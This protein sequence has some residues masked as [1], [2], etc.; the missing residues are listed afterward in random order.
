MGLNKNVIKGSIILLV[1]FG[2]FN[3]LNFIFQLSMARALSFA[4]YAVLATLFSIIYILAVFSESIQMIL[5]KYS[6]VEKDKGKLNNILRRSLK[7]TS[8]VAGII[9][10]IYLVISFPLAYLLKID[11]L[12]LAINGVIIFMAFISP[13][14]RGVM[15]GKKKFKAL[16]INMVLESGIKLVL[17]VLFVF[18]GWRVYG[19]LIGSIIGAIVALVL[20]FVPLREILRTKEKKSK[21]D[22]IYSFAV[23]AFFVTL[24]IVVF[25]SIDMVIAKIMFS[26]EIAGKY[27]IASILSKIVFW[28]TLPIS[29][30][31]FPLSSEKKKKSDNSG[32]IFLSSL[33]LLIFGILSALTVFYLFPESIVKL[34]SNRVIDE[35]SNILFYLGVS[36]GLLSLANLVLLHKLSRNKVSVKKASSL[37]IFVA[38][39]IFLL[40]YF[41]SNLFEFSIA[42][43]SACVIFL[44]GTLTLFKE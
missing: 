23:P 20:S 30:A 18:I 12:L 41:S 6:S 44:W 1:S 11:Y 22:G 31:M 24:V 16:G 3:F 28:G 5:A 43:M 34:F 37:F 25:Y 42:F 19:A 10:L 13:V 32:D 21:T 4:D 40:V 39:E 33:A 7:K 17:A 14:T 9:F 36:T 27:A 38:I 15:Q 35:A 26:E 2:I 29:K 8:F